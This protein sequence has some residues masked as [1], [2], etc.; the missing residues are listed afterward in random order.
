MIRNV[1]GPYRG[2]RFE[3][4]LAPPGREFLGFE[5][6]ALDTVGVRVAEDAETG[7]LLSVLLSTSRR[8]VE[9]RG[10]VLAGLRAADEANAGTAW[11]AHVSRADI[12]AALGA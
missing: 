6:D 1:H 4:L 2:L 11:Y 10:R 8:R 7:P 12:E 3:D 9:A 5:V